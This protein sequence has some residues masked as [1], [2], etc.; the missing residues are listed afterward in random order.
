M[1]W[2]WLLWNGTLT[3]H[4]QPAQPSWPTHLSSTLYLEALLRPNYSSSTAFH[5]YIYWLQGPNIY[6]SK[7]INSLLNNTPSSVLGHHYTPLPMLRPL[8]STQS[9]QHCKKVVSGIQNIMTNLV[10]YHIND[11]FFIQCYKSNPI[12]GLDRPRGFQEVKV[13]SFHDNGTGWL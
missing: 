3:H 13:P 5:F 2:P 7:T 11:S 9:L 1:L 12:T 4:S 6:I 10:Y 8:I